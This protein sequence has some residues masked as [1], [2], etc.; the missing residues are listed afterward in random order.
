MKA[1][2]TFFQGFTITA[3][4][5][6]GLYSAIAISNRASTPKVYGLSSEEAIRA[7]K[8]QI[9]KYL[10]S[11]NRKPCIVAQDNYVLFLNLPAQLALK[12]TQTAGLSVEAVF[13]H[14]LNLKP[15]LQIIGLLESPPMRMIAFK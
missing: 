8:L 5:S 6:N 12:T 2:K 13:L 14:L 15:S 11:T 1:T 7:C 4:E 10:A 9:L 3:R